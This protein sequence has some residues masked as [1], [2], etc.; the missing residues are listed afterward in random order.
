[1]SLPVSVLFYLYKVF[2]FLKTDENVCHGIC[3][4]QAGG[5]E[6]ERESNVILF[7]KEEAG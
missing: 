1:M 6:R 5:G 3:F 4:M 2:Y 7:E